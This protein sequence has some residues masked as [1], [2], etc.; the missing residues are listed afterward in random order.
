MTLREAGKRAVALAIAFFFVAAVRAADPNLCVACHGDGGNSTNSAIPSIAGQPR[1][2]LTTALYMFRE[3][4]RKDP[5]MSP[6]AA[7]LTNAEMNELA[8]HFSK[9]AAAPPRHTARPENARAGPALVRKFNCSQCHGPQMLGLQQMPRL[10]GQQYE[11]LR[12]Q[13]RAFKTA[14][15]QDLDGKMTE[16]A[17]PLSEQ[18]IEALAD[19]LAGLGG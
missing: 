6:M 2:S 17:Q 19:Y 1:Q 4:Y 10:A 16:S 14:A 9:Q 8:E 7:K 15:R 13:L 5:Q 12:A 11:Y 18:D 3:G